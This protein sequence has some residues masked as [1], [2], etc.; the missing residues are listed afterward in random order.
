MVR[1]EGWTV[2]GFLAAGPGRDTPALVLEQ[3]PTLANGEPD[4]DAAHAGCLFM[5]GDEP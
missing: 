2:T 1:P 3:L 4:L 5:Q